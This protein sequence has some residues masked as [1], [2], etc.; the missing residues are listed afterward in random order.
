MRISLQ[1]QALA[2]LS[3]RWSA[4]TSRLCSAFAILQPVRSINPSITQPKVLCSS[5]TWMA[6][7]AREQPVLAVIQAIQLSTIVLVSD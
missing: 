4:E 7:S 2:G 1:A 6:T 5:R 3:A